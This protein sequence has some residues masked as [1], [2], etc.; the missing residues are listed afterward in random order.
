MIYLLVVSLVWAFSFGLIKGNLTGLDATFVAG[1]RLLI[2][3]LVFLPFLRV[4]GLK[5]KLTWQLIG[6]GALQYG[7]MYITYI[8]AYP[9][10]KAYEIALF[11][12][13]TPIYVTLINDVLR[14]KF[15]PLHLGLAALA[16]LGTGVVVYS[17]MRQSEMLTG[18]LLM[19]ISNL[20]FAFGQVA[21][22]AVLPPDVKVK[23][24]H[25]FGLLYLGGV[26]TTAIASLFFTDWGAVQVTR[27]QVWTLLYLGVV[28]SGI[29]FFL[30]NMGAR[31]VEVGTLAIFNDL[32]VPLS[33]LVSLLVFGEEA[34][35]V[36]L[37]IGGGIVLAALVLSERGLKRRAARAEV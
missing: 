24:Q 4:K 19:Q 9:Y 12:I 32:K 3:L 29:S 13:F 36:R 17:G 15:Q 35:V 8:A 26:L 34:D 20:C 2:S 28:A 10:L 18:F 30:W 23:E 37:L 31:R 14:R 33:I 6:I 21:Y 11:T 25:I 5:R 7:V 22:K 16:V 27:L 1:T